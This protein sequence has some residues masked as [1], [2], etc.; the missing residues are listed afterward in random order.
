MSQICNSAVQ[1]R[2]HVNRQRLSEAEV[3]I[4]VTVFQTV[5]F[6]VLLLGI[7]CHALVFTPSSLTL[8]PPSKLLYFLHPRLILLT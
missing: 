1:N 8:S 7:P 6:L 2:E 3:V 4:S 5:T